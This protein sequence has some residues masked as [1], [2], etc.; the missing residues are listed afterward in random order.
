M[1][2]HGKGFT[3]AQVLAQDKYE[4]FS[5]WYHLAIRSLIGMYPFKDDYFWLAR[6]VDPPITTGQAEKSVKL[7]KRLGLVTEG[8]NG[9]L[10]LSGLSLTTG[11]EVEGLG[12][13]NLYFEC[14]DLA[15]NAISTMDRDT[16]NITALTLGISKA[17]YKEICADIAEFQKKLMAKANRD[18][19]ADGVY[20]MNFYLFPISKTR[21]SSKRWVKK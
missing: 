3:G 14:A 18:A 15:K 20:Q 10:K 19:G 2:A 5:R 17:T 9:I 21:D 7:L 1:S 4:F 8:P 6:K 11:E 13:R 16:R 12:L